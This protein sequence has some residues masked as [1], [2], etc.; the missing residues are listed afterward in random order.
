MAGDPEERIAGRGRY[1]RTRLLPRAE[2]VEDLRRRECAEVAFE[3][4][5]RLVTRITT[6]KDERAIFEQD[7]CVPPTGHPR[8]DGNLPG[9][10]RHIV[11]KECLRRRET[12]V[13]GIR[14]D[15]D[16]LVAI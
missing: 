14:I 13:R 3:R 10:N 2:E 16:E 8:V 12:D 6:I 4:L 7:T 5:D 11:A 9:M 15:V 1:L